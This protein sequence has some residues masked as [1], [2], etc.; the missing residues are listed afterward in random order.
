MESDMVNK[1]ADYFEKNGWK[2]NFPDKIRGIQPD[3][4][5]S[6]NGKLGLIEIKGTKGNIDQGIKQTLH[7]KN[8]GNYAYLA[9]PKSAI[10][11]NLIDICRGL[12]LGLLKIDNV[13]TQLIAPA[14]TEALE[15]VKKKLLGTK[16]EKSFLTLKTSL[17]KLFRT[18]SLILILKLLFLN[19]SREFHLNE[20]ARR[21]NVSASTVLKELDNLHSLNLVTKKLK[22]N[23]TLYQINKQGIIF[24]ELRKIFLKYELLDEIISK[25]LDRFDI[26]FAL[27]FG[28]FAKGTE[29]ENSDIDLLIISSIPEDLILDSVSRLEE[30]TGREIHFILWTQ[31]EFYKK[32]KERNS[33]LLNIKK[34]PRI[35]VIGNEK[36]FTRFIK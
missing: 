2:L 1:V 33:L 36:D 27:I 32:A 28:S 13:V 6:K 26:N 14:E 17:E 7:L 31:E 35:M 3:L 29:K 30:K 34:N 16:T 12:G 22:G 18:T 11:D 21:I 8:A 25:E 20:I 19:S 10:K 4:M 24:E 15:S 9:L 5:V 23:M